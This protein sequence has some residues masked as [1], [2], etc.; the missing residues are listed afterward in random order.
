MGTLIKK[1]EIKH[2]C[3]L[4]KPDREQIKSGDVYQCE[5]NK[6]YTARY[7]YDPGIPK[8]YL[9]WRRRYWPWP[10][11]KTVVNLPKE[12]KAGPVD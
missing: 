10:R 9:T 1:D 7:N 12:M 4:P 3:S 8:G 6:R 2:F 11:A 5:C